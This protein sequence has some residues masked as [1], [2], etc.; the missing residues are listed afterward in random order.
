[1]IPNIDDYNQKKLKGLISIQKINNENYAISTKQY[2]AEDGSE[3]PANV[4]GITISEVD[5]KINDLVSQQT[6]L[7]LLK[8]DLLS[9]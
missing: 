2:S 6:E 8:N 3:L 7:T 5:A 1:M 9:V 4:V